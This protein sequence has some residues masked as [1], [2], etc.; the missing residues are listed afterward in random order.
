MH[1]I[2]RE[3]AHVNKIPKNNREKVEINAAIKISNSN[4]N[5]FCY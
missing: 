2:P 4:D 3:Y 1:E 5:I